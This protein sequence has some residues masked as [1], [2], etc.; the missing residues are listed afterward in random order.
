[1][2]NLL[3]VALLVLFCVQP[4]QADLSDADACEQGKPSYSKQGMTVDDCLC[5]LGEAGKHMP[6]AMKEAFVESLLAEE[7]N[8]MGRIMGLGLTMEEVMKAMTDYSQ[9]VQQVCGLE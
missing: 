6:P 4:V 1:M 8:P 7:P 5:T 2:K 3:A 9:A